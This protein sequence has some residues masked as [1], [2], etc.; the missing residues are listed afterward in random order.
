MN[1]KPGLGTRRFEGNAVRT[2]HVAQKWWLALKWELGRAVSACRPA[3]VQREMA[4]NMTSE[5]KG[6]REE[7]S[8]LLASMARLCARARREDSNLAVRIE[9]ALGVL[10]MRW[11][12][13]KPRGPVEAGDTLA[14][15]GPKGVTVE[16]CF[17]DVEETTSH[18]GRL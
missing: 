4:G 10:I 2:A 12:R 16:R 17:P 13:Y 18:S 8:E 1:D 5:A 9:Q 7:F 15:L 11:P 14:G 3:S 6:L